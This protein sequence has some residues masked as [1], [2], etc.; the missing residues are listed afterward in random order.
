MLKSQQVKDYALKCGADIVG[1]TSMDRWEGAPTQCDARFIAPDAKSMIVM[2]FRIPR[3]TLRGIEEG[4][5]FIPYASMGYA[6]INFILQPMVCWKVTAMLEDEGYESVPIPNNFGWNNTD[7]NGQIPDAI[8]TTNLAKSVPVEPGKPAPDVF[9][10][11][12]FAAFMAGLGEIGWSK[13]FLS[14]RFGPRQRL[15]FIITDAPLEPDPIYEG[16]SL[17]DRCMMCARDCTGGAIPTDKSVKVNVAGHDLEWADINYDLCRP[18]FAGGSEEHNPFM[19]TEE[20]RKGFQLPSGRSNSFK[21]PATYSYGRALEG[22]SGCIRAC[23][24][25]LEEQG[26]LD[27]KFETPFRRRKPWRI[28]WPRQT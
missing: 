6:A 19:V 4:T 20:D 21:I 28:P 1:I 23:M 26:K 27:N 2:G 16:P 18:Y 24:I 7:F 25:H 12:R 5:F 22:A 14:P 13:M 10:H 11:A 17:C 9:L 3:G 8:S 15:A